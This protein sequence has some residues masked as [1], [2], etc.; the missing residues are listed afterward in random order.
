WAVEPASI[1]ERRPAPWVVAAPSPPIIGFPSPVA[2]A[3]RRPVGT[4]R[5]SPRVAV[6]RRVHPLPLSGQLLG[7]VYALWNVP[8]RRRPRLLE[9]L[10][11]AIRPG[12]PF[13]TVQPRNHLKLGIR[14]GPARHQRLL[15][16]HHL[17][18][19]W[20]KH[21]NLTRARR[22]VT[23][24]VIRHGDPIDPLPGWPDGDGRSINLYLSIGIAKQ[25]I[26]DSSPPQLHL[27]S[28]ILQVREMHFRVLCQTHETGDVELYF[29]PRAGGGLNRILHHPRGILGGRDIIAGITPP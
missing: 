19:L 24:S 29:R 4:D 5:R 17:R 9:S 7:T 13:V 25:T 3:I 12:I 16:R 1:V 26:G 23:L 8:L 27:E 15:R 20:C 6:I 18:P 2:D 14:V 10:I 11:T 21:F 28:A 22:N